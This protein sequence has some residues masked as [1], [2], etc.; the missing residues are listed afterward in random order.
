MKA[1]SLILG[2][3][4]TLA[5][6]AC[7]ASDRSADAPPAAAPAPAVAMEPATPPA[8][9]PTT[10]DPAAPAS[11]AHAGWYMEHGDMGMFQ[12]CGQEQQLTVD[13]ADLRARA[14]DFGL[15][16]NTPVYVRLA[17]SSD[18]STFTVTGIEQFGSP[19]P[20]R[21]CGLTGVV[22]PSG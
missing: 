14:K 18:G 15:E 4:M 22:M 20:M 12:L 16:P 21:D 5:M 7:S 3:G 17:G 6:C 11:A 13:S 9:P 10:A 2:L 1:I 19:E 8:A